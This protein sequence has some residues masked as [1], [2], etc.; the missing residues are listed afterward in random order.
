MLAVQHTDELLESHNSSCAGPYKDTVNLPV[1]KFNMRANSVQREPEL[2][3]QWAEQ[4]TYERLRDGNPG[5]SAP[6]MPDLSVGI[7]NV[8]C[9]I[10]CQPCCTHVHFDALGVLYCTGWDP[11]VQLSAV[12]LVML[13]CT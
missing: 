8:R 9:T 1:T 5:V 13:S 6:D 11:A 2:Q 3:R 10:A 7:P 12:L 4:R